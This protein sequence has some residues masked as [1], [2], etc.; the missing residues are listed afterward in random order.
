MTDQLINNDALTKTTVTFVIGC[1][2]EF[3]QVVDSEK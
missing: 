1:Q 3:N 2:L